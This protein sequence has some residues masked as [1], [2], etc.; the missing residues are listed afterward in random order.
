M[1][2]LVRRGQRFDV[3]VIDPPSFAQRQSSIAGGLRAYRRLTALGLS[4]VRPGGVVLQASC[5]SRITADR[6][7]DAIVSVA[8]GRGDDL[9]EIALTGH[10]LDHP[11]G[12]PEG[13]Y[14]KAMIARVNPR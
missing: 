11:I 4:L 13:A 8:E 12:F 9:D 1:G 5:S 10:A 3:V 14:L 2:A 6:F 7:F